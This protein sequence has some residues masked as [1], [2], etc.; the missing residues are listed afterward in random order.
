MS[1]KF[2]RSNALTPIG[3]AI[4]CLLS[5]GVAYAQDSGTTH[6]RSGCDR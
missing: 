3:A 2:T 6:S 1:R 5:N 4:L